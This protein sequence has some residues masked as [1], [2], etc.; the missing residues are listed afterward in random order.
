MVPLLH[1]GSRTVFS[2][3]SSVRSVLH[4]IEHELNG[5]EWRVELTQLLSFGLREVVL[6][7]VTEDISVHSLEIE[8]VQPFQYHSERV[9]EV[10]FET[11]LASAFLGRELPAFVPAHPTTNR[12]MSSSYRSL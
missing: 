10:V 5:F 12:K 1:A 2:P 7:D 6:V 3:M 8:A 9:I 11:P 4:R